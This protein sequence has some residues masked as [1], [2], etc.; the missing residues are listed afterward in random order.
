MKV[1][2]AY[3]R[4]FIDGKIKANIVD[5]KLK[6]GT[7]DDGFNTPQEAEHFTKGYGEEP[8]CGSFFNRTWSRLVKPHGE[9]LVS[10]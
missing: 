8:T 7:F 2:P 1:D 10:V 9:I 3:R 4:D 6:M 5:G